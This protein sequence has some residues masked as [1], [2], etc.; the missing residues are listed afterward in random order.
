MYIKENNGYKKK[1]SFPENSEN[2]FDFIEQPNNLSALAVSQKKV[3]TIKE[4]INDS[5]KDKIN[6]AVTILSGPIIGSAGL[7]IGFIEVYDIPFLQY[8]QNSFKMFEMILSWV[9][10]SLENIRIFEEHKNKNIIDE[11]LQIFNMHYMK[12]RISEEFRRG[13]NNPVSLSFVILTVKRYNEIENN[14]RLKLMFLIGRIIEKTVSEIHI[15]SKYILENQI[16]ILIID[17]KKE[18]RD[19]IIGRL[20][21]EINEF[22]IQPYINSV[23]IIEILLEGLTFFSNESEIIKK[24][25]NDKIFI[26]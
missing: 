5:D 8:N 9:S 16:S 11:Q 21:E 18:Q 3:V 12:T 15:A 10:K 4:I 17:C 24:I 1:I 23:D 13:Y 20:T 26:H 22:S 2:S 6:N 25:E 19:S 7:C 14:S